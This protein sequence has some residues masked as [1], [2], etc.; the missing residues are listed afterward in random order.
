MLATSMA[1]AGPTL[2]HYLPIATTLLAAVFLAILLRRGHARAF[3][4]HLLW[5][6]AGIAAYGAGTALESAITLF[7]NSTELTRW[8][9]IA[10]ALLGGYPLGTG[11]A[12]LLCKR[13]AAHWLTAIS[14]AVVLALSIAVLL[15]PIDAAKLEPHRPTG[16]VLVWSWIRMCT[17]AVNL[18]AAMFLIGGALYSAVRFWHP[19]AGALRDNARALGTALIAGGALLPAIGGGMAKAGLVEALYVGEFLGLILILAGHSACRRAPRSQLAVSH[20]QA[21]VQNERSARSAF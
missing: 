11:S 2:L 1:E 17:P 7:G 16:H 3:P 8:W 9:Y 5:W 18:Y 20:S 15:S 4:P 21:T 6:S 10:G 12:Y 19:P 14:G 13:R